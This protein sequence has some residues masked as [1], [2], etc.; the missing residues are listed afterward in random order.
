MDKKNFAIAKKVADEMGF[1][2]ENLSLGSYKHKMSYNAV[3]NSGSKWNANGNEITEVIP[4]D[5]YVREN[6]IPR[7]DF[8]K[9]DVEGAE[10]DILKG[11]KTTIA[12]F[13]PILAISAYHK[14]DDFWVLMNYIKSV[15]PDYEF[16]MRQ[17]TETAD[18][19]PMNISTNYENYL[20]SLGLEPELRFF[21]EC[22]LFAR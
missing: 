21:W 12:R 10:L 5:A 2:V 4:L 11:A 13:K 22:V 20:Y 16:A 7:V 19:E 18:E 1:V 15:R 6:N 17:G 14:P 8:I 3:G 9:L